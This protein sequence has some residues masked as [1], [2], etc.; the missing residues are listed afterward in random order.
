ME[1]NLL[2]I[3]YIDPWNITL[4]VPFSLLGDG[5]CLSDTMLDI[6]TSLA[7]VEGLDLLATQPVGEYALRV[8]V[9]KTVGKPERALSFVLAVV[10]GC[11][12]ITG[13]D[14]L[15][16]KYPESTPRQFER[17]LGH[18]V[19]Q[20][21]KDEWK[22]DHREQVRATKEQLKTLKREGEWVIDLLFRLNR[23]IEEIDE[24]LPKQERE[25]IN[26]R[27]ALKRAHG[28]AYDIDRILA[29]STRVEKAGDAIVETRQWLV[30]A[31]ASR[32]E[33]AWRFGELDR[34]KRSSERELDELKA[35]RCP[36]FYVGIKPR[37]DMVSLRVQRSN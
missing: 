4:N 29:C 1:P 5:P 31:D 24:A 12:D 36:K 18:L 6:G 20:L 34:Y 33:M 28:A 7:L 11:M 9:A 19:Q 15:R 8:S 14:E 35:R 22:D 21:A 32:R 25:L 27:R 16:I 17:Q 30:G 10:V 3:E 37:G 2:V 13:I 23:R 26:A